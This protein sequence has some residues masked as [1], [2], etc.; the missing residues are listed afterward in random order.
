MIKI[1]S[2]ELNFAKNITA[3]ENERIFMKR[4]THS[5]ISQS[6]KLAITVSK[7]ISFI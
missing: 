7:Q 3:N 4:E 1:P 5:N 6:F 2:K